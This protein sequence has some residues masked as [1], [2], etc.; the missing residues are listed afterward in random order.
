MIKRLHLKVAAATLA[1]VSMLACERGPQS[2][3]SVSLTVPG[4]SSAT[5]W[6][7]A[8]GSFG[9]TNAGGTDVF[10]A[11]S[12][13]AGQT[14][15]SPTL[16]NAIAGE[17]FL[18]G[19]FPPRVA[20]TARSGSKDTEVAVLWTTRGAAPEIKTARSRDGGRTF[21]P[22]VTLQ[23]NGAAGTRGWPALTL[24]QHG[25]AHSIWLDHRGMAAAITHG[26]GNHPG[27]RAAVPQDGV[28]AAQESG[29][30]YAAVV[31]LRRGNKSS[32]RACATAARP[33][34]PLAR[35]ARFTPR[36]VTFT[37]GTFAT[38]R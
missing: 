21:E 7:A 16:V 19:E 31:G 20:L 24:N 8:S 37:R 27:H 25:T 34:W 33:R 17:A 18:G 11:V 15:S 38:W 26:A 35:T 6:V 3:D 12:R 28:A 4:R 10:V 1:T 23:A 30:Y 9:A 14:F 29:L 2:S 22:P 13:D 5:P 32:P 36:G